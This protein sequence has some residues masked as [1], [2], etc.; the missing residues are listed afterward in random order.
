VA[1]QINPGQINPGQ[2]DPGQ[3]DPGSAIGAHR[4]IVAVWRGGPGCSAAAAPGGAHL[5]LEH[6]GAATVV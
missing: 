4:A 5:L 3:I 2:I 1:V 6:P